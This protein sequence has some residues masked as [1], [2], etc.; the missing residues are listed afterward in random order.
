MDYDTWLEAGGVIP[1]DALNTVG[2]ESLIDTVKA[3][4]GFLDVASSCIVVLDAWRAARDEPWPRDW[5]PIIRY[6]RRVTAS[7]EPG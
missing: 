7:Q 3:T 6:W 2:S 5:P 1:P 4:D